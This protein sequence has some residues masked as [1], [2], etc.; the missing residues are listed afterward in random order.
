M[1]YCSQFIF[2]KE[3]FMN[4][5][6]SV[7]A[8][9]VFSLVLASGLEAGHFRVRLREHFDFSSVRYGPQND[10]A[11]YFG[12]TNTVNLWY[13]EPFRWAFGLAL[14]PVLGSWK[15]DQTAPSGTDPKVRLWNAGVEGKYFFFPGRSNLSG[16][17]GRLGLTANWLDTRGSE[18]TLA[19]GGYYVGA[20]WEFKVWKLGLAPEAAFRHVFLERS[21]SIASFTPSIGVHF[22][23]LP[24]DER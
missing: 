24:D 23:V 19:G 12:A 20:G 5:R 8:A 10:E 11:H 18:G 6:R 14:N 4:G 1:V 17:F 16:F 3:A 7:F 21:G 13:E 22:Y 2:L 15:T 9:L